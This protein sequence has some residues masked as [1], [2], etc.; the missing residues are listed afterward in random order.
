MYNDSDND[1]M[2]KAYAASQEKNKE[3]AKVI[4]AKE[5][6]YG[7]DYLPP[8]AVACREGVWFQPVLSSLFES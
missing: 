2:M 7:M 5:P 8:S 4:V 3:A 1:E 6:D